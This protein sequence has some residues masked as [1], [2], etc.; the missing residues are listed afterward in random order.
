MARWYCDSELPKEKI[1]F[2][3][4]RVELGNMESEEAF[5][6]RLSLCWL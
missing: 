3:L 6:K 5:Y 1:E 2:E 4:V